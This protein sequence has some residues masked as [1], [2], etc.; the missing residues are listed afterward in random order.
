MLGRLLFA[1]K[2][3]L[4]FLAFLLSVYTLGPIGLVEWI[5][6]GTK[7]CWRAVE[8]LVPAC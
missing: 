7:R 4:I 2:H 3:A 6:L 5:V 1:L 8:G